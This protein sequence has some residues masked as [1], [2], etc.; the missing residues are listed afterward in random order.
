MA[1][2]PQKGFDWAAEQGI[3]ALLIVRDGEGFLEKPTPAFA[4]LFP[5]PKQS[6]LASTWLI[7]AGVFLLAMLLMAVGVI[8]RNRCMAGSCGGLAAMRDQKGRPLCDACT[9]A[10]TECQ[11]A[12]NAKSPRADTAEP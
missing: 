2:G 8:F 9:K 11:V 10:D 4:E 3:A 5:E 7:A 6:S 12:D 1:L